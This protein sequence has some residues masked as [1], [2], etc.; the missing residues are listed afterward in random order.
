[1]GMSYILYLPLQII[2]LYHWGS[3]AIWLTISFFQWEALTNWKG[4]GRWSGYLFF[5]LLSAR[6]RASNEYIPLLKVTIPVRQADFSYSCKSHG[7]P[8]TSPRP[9]PFRFIASSKWL[10]SCW[11]PLTLPIPSLN[12]LQTP[13]LSVPSFPARILDDS[14]GR[15]RS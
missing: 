4:R 7:V 5:H 15:K 12:S 9:C 3:L 10:S 14:A 11:F 13:H 6:L 2:S 1:M 8:V